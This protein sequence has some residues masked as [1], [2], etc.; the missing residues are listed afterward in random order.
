[1]VCK[2]NLSTQNNIVTQCTTSG[3]TDLRDNHATATKFVI[4][5]NLHQIINTRTIADNRIIKSATVNTCVGPYFH[6][7]TNNHPAQLRNTVMLSVDKLKTETIVPNARTTIYI[8]VVANVCIGNRC[9]ASNTASGTDFTIM[10]NHRMR[11]NDAPVTNFHIVS[12]HRISTNKTPLSYFGACGN[13]SACINT[14]FRLIFGIHIFVEQNKR[15]LRI[16]YRQNNHILWHKLRQIRRCNTSFS[17]DIRGLFL[18]FAVVK[19]ANILCCC[20]C[21]CGNI[22]NFFGTFA[23]IAQN[24]RCNLSHIGQGHIFFFMI[25]SCIYHFCVSLQTGTEVQTEHFFFIITFFNNRETEVK[26]NFTH[27]R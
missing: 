11:L 18:T 9:P 15:Q 7:V 24:G 20:A 5:R 3:N 19:K 12:N 1:M 23:F 22:C 27:R 10:S 13:F 6:I 21:H 25:K 8:A 16:F 4:M 17:L 14:G 2:P 26:V